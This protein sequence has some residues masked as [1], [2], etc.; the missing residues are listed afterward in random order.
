MT[1]KPPADAK[2]FCSGLEPGRNLMLC[3]LTQPSTK[4]RRWHETQPL[5]WSALYSPVKYA[6]ASRGLLM[7]LL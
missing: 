2:R 4:S 5:D 6:M 3:A 7:Q 1:T